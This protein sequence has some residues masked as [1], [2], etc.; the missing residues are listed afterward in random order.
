[1]NG[2]IVLIVIL[3]VA[4]IAVSIVV[5]IVMTTNEKARR[6]LRKSVEADTPAPK[7]PL[8]SD[9]LPGVDSGATSTL[10]DSV[11]ATA[12]GSGGGS[13]SKT[14][15]GTT[16]YVSA[17]RFSGNLHTASEPVAPILS[18]VSVIFEDNE[19]VRAKICFL[20]ECENTPDAG[21]CDACGVRL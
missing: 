2:S 12:S 6:L 14:F 7:Y 19:P 10:I 8:P 17:L 3:L 4:L 15:T 21:V 5:L 1:M 11:T 9:A 13:T 16:R 18:G 20:C